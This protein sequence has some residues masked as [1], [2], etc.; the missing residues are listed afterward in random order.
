MAVTTSKYGLQQV[1]KITLFDIATGAA[2]VQLEDMKESKFTN[3]QETVYA[4]GGGSNV[5]LIGFDHSKAASIGGSNALITDGIL[6][7]QLGA[8]V[9]TTTDETGII[10]TDIITTTVADEATTHLKATGTAGS[11]IKYV[12]LRNDDGSLGTKFTQA[13]TAT[14]GKF[15][16]APLTKK[17]SFS[18]DAVPVGSTIVAFYKPTASTAKKVVAKTDVFS[19]S[20]KVVADCLLRDAC[21][22]KDYQGQIVFETG[23][24]KGA[25]EWNVTAGGE[26][27]VQAFEIEALKPCNDNE[28]W[29]MFVYDESDLT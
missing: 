26:P 12:Y 19:K 11:E 7:V 25:F 16:Y 4:K 21:T 6:A 3:G 15:A 10:Y 14:S 9:E 13:A 8:D 29:K 23:K 2:Y 1:F 24:V 18:T 17:I 27:S 28:L 22:K 20:V 5:N